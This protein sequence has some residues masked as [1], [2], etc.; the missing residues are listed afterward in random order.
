MFWGDADVPERGGLCPRGRGNAHVLGDAHVLE[1][2]RCPREG[3][4]R[5]GEEVH[6]PKR[7]V[8]PQA[9]CRELEGPCGAAQSVCCLLSPSSGFP[10]GQRGAPTLPHAAPEWGLCPAS[11][12]PAP[13]NPP[14]PTAGCQG[15]TLPPLKGMS[16]TPGK[17][18]CLRCPPSCKMPPLATVLSPRKEKSCIFQ[19]V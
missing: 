1:G 9:G 5:P 12:S 14:Y 8:R 17:H 11:Y 7:A 18:V 13:H 6:M 15:C 16:S 3:D 4:A 10:A 2:C 19:N